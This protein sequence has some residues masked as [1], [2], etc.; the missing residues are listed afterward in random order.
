MKTSHRQQIYL[1][2]GCPLLQVLPQNVQLYGT[3]FFLQT[4]QKQNENENKKQQVVLLVVS[5]VYLSARMYILTLLKP[6][7]PYAS[8]S[9]ENVWSSKAIGVI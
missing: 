3:Y 8:C 5:D 6:I 9:E 2:E 4:A 1:Q 7:E